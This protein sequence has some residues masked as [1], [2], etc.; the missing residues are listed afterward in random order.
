MKDLTVGQVARYLS[1]NDP[2]EIEAAACYLGISVMEARSLPLHKIEEA[3]LKLSILDSIPS[4]FKERLWFKDG[5]W[6]TEGKGEEYGIIND[7]NAITGGEYADIKEYQ[8]NFYPN[9][10]RI[11]SILYRPV[12]ERYGQAYKVAEYKGTEGHEKFNTLPAK[13]LN[14]AL[15]F[16][17][18]VRKHCGKSLISYLEGRVMR[19]R[20][21]GG[22]TVSSSNLQ[23]AS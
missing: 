21:S 11:L 9:A 2:D 10:T 1:I 17:R 6:N 18:M 23:E 8:N 12:V 22:G 13:Y 14:G 7:F 3:A 19:S 16:F 20:K 4:L 15:F 5:E